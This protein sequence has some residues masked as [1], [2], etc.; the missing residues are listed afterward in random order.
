MGRFG[1]TILLG[2]LALT[3]PIS[4]MAADVPEP[5]TFY[6]PPPVEEEPSNFYLRLDFG[7]KH[8]TD[9]D[10]TFD[11]PGGGYDVPGNGEF[12]D[13]TIGNSWMVG[14]GLGWD[15]AGMFRFDITYDYEWPGEFEGY[16][17]CGGCDHDPVDEYSH[18]TANILAH[19]FLLNAY[20]DLNKNGGQVTPY[21]G[22]GIGFAR[23]TT[24]NVAFENP[25]TGTGTWEGA[26][27]WNFAWSITG[28]LGIEVASNMIV[29]LNY[30]YVHLGTALAYTNLNGNTPIVY[31][32]INAHEFRVGLRFLM[33]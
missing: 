11:W 12:I 23:L 16:L 6:Y 32:N 33:P 5:P 1:K 2:G 9:P 14:F 31:D 29:D 30:R 8:Y 3:L 10:V 22:G 15:P 27:T 13:E 4:A 7:F 18:E 28:G 26:T 21:I 25:D 24:T 19:T 17:Y 20:L